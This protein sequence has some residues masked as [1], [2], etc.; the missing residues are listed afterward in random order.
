MQLTSISKLDVAVKQLPQPANAME[1][2][3]RRLEHH[4]LNLLH[5]RGR[6]LKLRLRYIAVPV[7]RGSRI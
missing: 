6:E 5:R 2:P 3:V 7:Q 1:Q 4:Y